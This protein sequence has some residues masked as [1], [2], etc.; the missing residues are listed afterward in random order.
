MRA[1]SLVL[2]LAAL[3]AANPHGARANLVCRTEL[4]DGR[5]L[6]TQPVMGQDG[7]FCRGRDVFDRRR[8]V[9]AERRELATPSLPH[10]NFTTPTAPF[11]TGEIGPFTTFSNSPPHEMRHR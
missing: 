3:M 9:F 1:V 7:I 11:T 2:V 8:D 5:I 6:F 10:M 4:A